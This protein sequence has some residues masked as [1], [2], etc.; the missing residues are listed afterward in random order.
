MVYRTPSALSANQLY[1][2]LLHD[3]EIA[4]AEGIL[5]SSDYNTGVVRPQKKNVV[6]ILGEQIRFSC[7]I[8]STVVGLC[9]VDGVVHEDTLSPNK[10][11]ML[12]F[13]P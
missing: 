6:I 9:N 7:Q 5:I 8:R 13:R 12:Y 3:G 4:F 2:L 10:G 11:T 1:P